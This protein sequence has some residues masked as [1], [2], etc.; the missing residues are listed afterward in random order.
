MRAIAAM[1]ERFWNGILPGSREFCGRERHG[2]LEFG[3]P[4]FT[5]SGDRPAGFRSVKLGDNLLK[6]CVCRGTSS[7]LGM[8]SPVRTDRLGS[9]SGFAVSGQ[10]AA[11]P[12]EFMSAAVSMV[13]GPQTRAELCAVSGKSPTGQNNE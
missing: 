7:L 1:V 13:E 10:A 11:G 6:K 12:E 8:A 5:P 4:R 2:Q 3:S 9:T